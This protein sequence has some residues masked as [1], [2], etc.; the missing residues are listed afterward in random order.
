MTAM[1]VLIAWLYVHTNSVA[2]S[3]LMHISSTGSLV[4]F[5][6]WRVNAAQE[7]AWYA[8]YGLTLWLAVSIII[9]IG[10]GHRI[11]WVIRDRTVPRRQGAHEEEQR[12]R[13]VRGTYAYYVAL[14]HGSTSRDCNSV[15]GRRSGRTRIIIL[16]LTG[17]ARRYVIE[18]FERR[19]AVLR[20]GRP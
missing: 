16:L 20:I 4:I 13:Q 10:R 6:A 18:I 17:A 2:L 3:Q 1:R 11:P 12:N 9:R 14:T 7:V 8:L 5:G 19:R 15:T